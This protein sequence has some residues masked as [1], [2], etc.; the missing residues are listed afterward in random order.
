MIEA[1]Q[2]SLIYSNHTVGLKPVDV[3][4]GPGE[5]VFLT[6]PSGSGKT[7]LLKLLMGTIKPSGGSLRVMGNDLIKTKDKNLLSMRRDIGPVF[8]EF[9]LVKGHTAL[10]NVMFGLRFLPGKQKEHMERAKEALVKVGLE[11]K[12][13]S[14]VEAMSW[15]ENQR[16]AI[17]R[18]V[19]RKPRL[20]L[21]DEPTGNLDEANALAILRLLASFRD[22]KTSVILSTH[23]TH[24]LTEFD[25]YREFQMK[26]G[27][28]TV[29]E[30][31]AH[32]Q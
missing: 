28:M 25:Q 1:T 23:A 11:H 18:A 2:I 14:K 13:E 24:L 16:V 10:E 8:Q 5:L 27:V 21:A 12:I 31:S 20:I 9:R 3:K 30:V 17:A 32:V 15:G 4:V 6:G 19:A 7:S 22:E 26:N 29:R